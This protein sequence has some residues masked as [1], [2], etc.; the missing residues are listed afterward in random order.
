MPVP[1]PKDARFNDPYCTNCGY[2]LVGATAAA[3]CPECG[4]P[5]V[6]VLARHTPANAVGI[7]S[8]RRRS[9]ATVFGFP[10]WEIALGPDPAKGERLGRARA[11]IAIGDQAFGGIAF[12]GVAAGGVCFGGVSIGLGAMGGLAVGVASA[13]GGM[14]VGGISA[15][16][17]SI[18]GLCTGGLAVGFAAQG[19]MAVGV[20]ARGG[21]VLGRH[22]IAPGA[23]PDPAAVDM[24]KSLAPIMGQSPPA[25]ILGG[26]AAM[27]PVVVVLGIDLVIAALVGLAALTLAKRPDP[28]SRP[29]P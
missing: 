1:P 19:G 17:A 11:L 10:V 2:L 14:A 4:R 15:G 16:G 23:T 8:V 25:A 20:Y 5:L 21:G 26:L 6:D 29:P 28:Y 9:N 27:R 24:F 12:G 13:A 3:E 7:R 18:G 22:V